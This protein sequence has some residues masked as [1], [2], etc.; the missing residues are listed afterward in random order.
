[1]RFPSRNQCGTV[2][3]DLVGARAEQVL[4]ILS[5]SFVELVMGAVGNFSV[6]KCSH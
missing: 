3:L 2:Y 1:M 6:F 5:D 4:N